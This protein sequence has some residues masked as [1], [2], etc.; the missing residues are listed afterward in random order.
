MK[1][2]ILKI[3]AKSLIIAIIGVFNIDY[4]SH[5]LFS[6]PMETFSYFVFKAF[7]YF[8]FSLLFFYFIDLR[9]HEIQNVI[10]GGIIVA[11]LFGLYYNVLPIFTYGYLPYGISLKYISFLGFG[12]FITGLFFGIVHTLSFIGGYYVSKI[13]K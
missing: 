1:K 2:D 11:G 7:F 5:L 12:N 8:V 3:F 10:F 13:I 6:S 4:F 9:K